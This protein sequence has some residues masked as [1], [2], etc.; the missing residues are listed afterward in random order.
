M[1]SLIYRRTEVIV[2]RLNTSTLL[3]R[4]IALNRKPP[5]LGLYTLDFYKWNVSMS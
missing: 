4:A 1:T 5:N 2:D 3:A